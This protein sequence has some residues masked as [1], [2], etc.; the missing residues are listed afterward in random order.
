MIVSRIAPAFMLAF[1][2]GCA[3]TQSTTREPGPKGVRERSAETQESGGVQVGTVD[4]ARAGGPRFAEEHEYEPLWFSRRV[5]R[6]K[7]RKPPEEARHGGEASEGL[8]EF[9]GEACRGIPPSSR[10]ACPVLTALQ[11]VEPTDGGFLVRFEPWVDLS[12]LVRLMK[13]HQAY[14]RA[15]GYQGMPFCPLYLLGLQ[16]ERRGDL[17]FFGIGSSRRKAL[18]Q[19]LEAHL[20]EEDAAASP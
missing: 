13:C 3:G 18:H 10:R 9:T 20:P 1:A 19:R 15:T 7:R 5:D 12:K 8:A 16:V 2:L 6:P 17:V 4:T 11:A 14:A